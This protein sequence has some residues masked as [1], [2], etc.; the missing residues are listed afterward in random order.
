MGERV[1][2]PGALKLSLELAIGEGSSG[3]V[4]DRLKEG[5]GG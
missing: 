1:D 2:S 4:F 3:V 5:G